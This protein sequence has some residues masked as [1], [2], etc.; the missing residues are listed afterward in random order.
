MLLCAWD[1][2]SDRFLP[3]S[4]NKPGSCRLAFYD[5]YYPRTMVANKFR[6]TVWSSIWTGIELHSAPTGTEASA[7]EP[8]WR[9]AVVQ[10]TEVPIQT[11]SSS[12]G[13]QCWFA[14]SV[15]YRSPQ[16]AISHV[17][18]LQFWFMCY[19]PKLAKSVALSKNSRHRNKLLWAKCFVLLKVTKSK[20]SY[21]LL[22]ALH[23]NTTVVTC[24]CLY[25]EK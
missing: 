3:T 12:M 16:I 18:Y 22:F 8:W 23:Y 5:L 17:S 6:G 1:S 14:S 13:K 10:I 20:I 2:V 24:V 25:I 7:M 15:S 4:R 19:D 11:L 9:R 21:I